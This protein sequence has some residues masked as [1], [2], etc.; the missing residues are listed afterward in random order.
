MSQGF[1][2]F[3]LSLTVSETRPPDVAQVVLELMA[4]LMS[5]PLCAR[6]TGMYHHVQ[7]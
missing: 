2:F 7:P 4:I 3:F 1:I 6:V 5:H